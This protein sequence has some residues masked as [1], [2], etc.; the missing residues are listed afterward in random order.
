[1]LTYSRVRSAYEANC[2]VALKQSLN[3][4]KPV[5]DNVKNT[6]QQLVELP[7]IRK[8]KGEIPLIGMVLDKI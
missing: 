4:L 1:M 3:A 5:T 7:N 2:A 8:N 6:K